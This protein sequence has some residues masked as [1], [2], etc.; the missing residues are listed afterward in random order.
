MTGIL[1][2]IAIALKNEDQ[3]KLAL[4]DLININGFEQAEIIDKFTGIVNHSFTGE[5][6]DLIEW[7]NMWIAHLNCKYQNSQGIN[8]TSPTCFIQFLQ[9]YTRM[10][11]L[12][13]T[14]QQINTNIGK[15]NIDHTL[16]PAQKTVSSANY[17][18]Y[19]IKKGLT[20]DEI[21]LLLNKEDGK[22]QIEF[23]VTQFDFLSQYL[24]PSL[25]IEMILND[26]DS[27]RLY[28]VRTILEKLIHVHGFNMEDIAELLK[29]HPNFQFLYLIYESFPTWGKLCFSAEQ[30]VF[31]AQQEEGINYLLQIKQCTTSLLEL[32]LPPET[33][34]RLLICPDG[35]KNLARLRA[36]TN[37]H[38][39]TSIKEKRGEV[40]LDDEVVSPDDLVLVNTYQF[41]KKALNNRDYLSLLIKEIE[42]GI[43]SLEIFRT[44]EYNAF[45]E[46]LA[47]AFDKCSIPGVDARNFCS[48]WQKEIKNQANK[49]QPEEEL[50]HF[51]HRIFKILS[52]IRKKLKSEHYVEPLPMVV[53]TPRVKNKTNKPK[54]TVINFTDNDGISKPVAQKLKRVQ[55]DREY[56]KRQ[57]QELINKGFSSDTASRILFKK[58][59]FLPKLLNYVE[60]L[61]FFL[62]PEQV[63]LIGLSPDGIEKLDNAI[64][65]YET[66]DDL[67]YNKEYFFIIIYQRK[68]SALDKYDE[69]IKIDYIK[70]NY[71]KRILEEA[72]TH[73]ELIQIVCRKNG[74]TTLNNFQKA[75]KKLKK[76]QFNRE[77]LIKA[78]CCDDG[79]LNLAK[80]QDAL[81]LLKNVH[82]RDSD[83]VAITNLYQDPSKLISI[84]KYVQICFEMGFNIPQ[85]NTLLYSIDAFDCFR[86]LE[87][88]R[89]VI[90]TM[91]I[92]IDQVIQILM[93]PNGV[94]AFNHLIHKHI[95]TE[96]N[97]NLPFSHQPE[98]LPKF[99]NYSPYY[100]FKDNQCPITFQSD[101]DQY[102]LFPS[103]S[104]VEFY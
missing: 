47:L 2:K 37:T 94:L 11:K 73:N 77:K 14:L 21:Q 88:N 12:Q 53:N 85:F 23:L 70:N 46:L 62:T 7:L 42:L 49:L 86:A 48:I 22:A 74:D 3:F 95:S 91:N 79:Y 4:N 36:L 55:K 57:H 39:T 68:T 99:S 44:D 51:S 50:K 40:L 69:L 97:N 78:L 104:D 34:N 58:N 52:L 80:I 16:D 72:L 87:R 9:N 81:A 63:G 26:K 89:D 64:A 29:Q 38:T 66:L 75:Y 71:N 100:F 35:K 17:Q 102:P 45:A 65:D 82:F 76:Y 54:G 103:I 67:Q 32:Q 93:K 43:F 101:S 56:F 31:V 25:I 96:L 90:K 6:Q 41:I 28:L 84:A 10:L 13:L 59:N 1:E 24:D 83:I 92:T 33:I 18:D 61:S 27:S 5:K 20:V 19:L 30:I 8:S 15:K 98:D 60:T